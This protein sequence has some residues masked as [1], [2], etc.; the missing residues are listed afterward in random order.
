MSKRQQGFIE[1]L[2]VVALTLVVLG[3]ISA[4]VFFGFY[5]ATNHHNVEF[6][7]NKAERVVDRGGKDAR[8]LV[9]TDKGT[10]EIT[11]SLVNG[12]F[13]SSDLYGSIV[14]GKKYSC[15]AIGFRAGFVSAYE[16]LLSCKEIK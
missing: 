9:Y 14:A 15:D 16:N 4:F 6:T 12:R 10:Y 3:T 2:V 7:V 13:N 11:D 1:E 5:F 8:Y